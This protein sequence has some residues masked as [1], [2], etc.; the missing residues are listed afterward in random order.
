MT[1]TI[2]PVPAPLEV[3][4]AGPLELALSLRIRVREERRLE[5]EIGQILAEVEARGA[6]ATYGYGSTLAWLRDASHLAT[7]DAK[8]V[9][10]RALAVNPSRG[11]MAPRFLLAHPSPVPPRPKASSGQGRSTRSSRR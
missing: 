1:S 8:K 7:G 6:K 11:W 2:N 3:W 4:R 9:V 5:A 10:N